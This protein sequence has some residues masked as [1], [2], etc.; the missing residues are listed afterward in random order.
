MPR[1]YRLLAT[2]ALA[3]V[4]AAALAQQSLI[5][6]SSFPAL[7]VADGRSTTTISAEV[8]DTSGRP[9]ADGTRIVF[10]TTLGSFRESVATTANGIARVI[11]VS[12]GAPGIAKITATALNGQ[13]APTTFEF[14]FVGDRSMLSNAREYIE[15]VAPG[16]MHYTGD[17]RV[18]G[19]SG[20]NKGVSL[21][22]RD[23]AID[24]DDMQ[25]SISTYELRARKARVKI[26]KFTK[27]F[28]QLYMKLDQRRGVGTT[29]Y[30]SKRPQWPVAYLNGL[31]FVSEDANG[32]LSTAAPLEEDRYGLVEL[33]GA[34]ISPASLAA[35][36]TSFEFE[37]L[38]GA[39]SRV[40]AKK[41]VIFPNRQIQFQRADIYV[42][43]SRVMK[44]PLFQVNLMQ[45][46]T[47]VVMEQMV[48]VNDN[49]VALNYPHYLS[50]KPGMTSLLRFRTGEQLGRGAATSRGAFLDYE[51][52]WNRGD[53]MEGSMAFR[54]IGRTDW[55]LGLN[56]YLR[57]DDR[58][59]VTAQFE[60]PGGR[61]IFGSGSVNRQFDGFQISFNAN[62]NQSIRGFRNTNQDMSLVAEK[63][64]T[65]VGKLP[66]RLYYGFVANSSAYSSVTD[67]GP[68][69]KDL[70]QS[71]SQNSA[72]LRVRLQSLP[73]KLDGATSLVTSFSASQL[74]GRNV[75]SGLTLLGHA[76]L[77]RRLSS[78]TSVLMNYDFTRDGFN[79]RAIGMHR[80]TLQG[81]FNA[82]RTNAS[83]FA[84]RS[85]D[86]DRMNIF[87]DLSYRV[88][89]LWRISGS[90]TL[91]RIL[92]ST[93]LDY[94][95]VL[96][97]RIGWREVG[98][99]WSKRTGR[100][101]IQLLGA[102]F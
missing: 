34:N 94:N 87:G 57:I 58:S 52:N 63:D 33:K 86:V 29:T 68:G 3:C 66:V 75:A 59:S 15:L 101:G 49:Q 6:L 83:I 96:G 65:K 47:P 39:P 99:M 69:N 17:S 79:D 26:G 1:P 78:S 72:G 8:R 23:I 97:Y 90:Y 91:D 27:D 62:A 64:P 93:F 20:A 41:A 84:S 98:L 14:E 10:N 45:N 51:M 38:S 67:G 92:G 50:L 77:S 48:N 18:M 19:A 74:S 82:G 2:A 43:D 46:N 70:I 53:R 24:A 9:V 76:T 13:A 25:L 22:Y 54:G 85:L 61:S 56:Q 81:F 60:M 100:I 89:G 42:A 95:L 7:S 5:K 11:L 30:R 102:S 44:L 55:S 32:N 40:A 21:R 36:N 71:R 31:A 88:G 80:L 73:V 12:G 28:D 4:C 37:D 35:R 16:V